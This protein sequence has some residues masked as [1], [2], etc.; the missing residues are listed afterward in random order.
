[1]SFSKYL[2]VSLCFAVSAASAT[3][4]SG[5]LKYQPLV[6]NFPEDSY[7]RNFTDSPT[8]DNNL[9]GRFNF[10]FSKNT[11]SFEAHYQL[12]AKTGDSVELYKQMQ[13][14][15]LIAP[16]FPDDSRRLF[17]LSDYIVDQDSAL[18]VHRLDRLNLTY[19]GNA[20]VLKVG[21]Q[22]ISWGNG[23]LFNPMDFFNPFDPTAVDKEYKTG[24]DM[25]Y[26]QHLFA[27]GSDAQF[28]WV[29]RRDFDG[30][31]GADFNSAA[32]KYHLF[33]GQHEVDLLLSKHYEDTLFSL[34][35]VWTLGGAIA[36]TDIVYT[37][38]EFDNYVSAVAN[39]SYSWLWFDKNISASLE[40]FR[41][42]F[43][44]DDGDYSPS[45]LLA[46]LDLLKRLER[47]ESFNL[48]K[49]YLAAT[50]T[51][52]LHPLWLVT[53]NV[54]YNLNDS[55]YLFQFVS[56]HDLASNLQLVLSVNLPGGNEGSEFG[57]IQVD[58]AEHY[59]SA[60]ASFFGQLSWYF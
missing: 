20:N 43:G 47:G 39:L 60:G 6:A 48:A 40:Y 57:G 59:L 4:W 52:E 21:R 56:S 1:M 30:E 49:D 32:G 41:N 51:I 22:A 29:G 24:D 53:P 46:N 3:D 44:I 26:A 58:V 14:L 19:S 34:G 9:D 7:F 54:F 25:V 2:L 12:L 13:G 42:G 8:V 31:R 37:E 45:T 5:H 36:R 11:L 50:A 38:T 18:L 17:N 23:L 15:E 10:S 27:N 55:S 16:F 28:V 35:G 33:V